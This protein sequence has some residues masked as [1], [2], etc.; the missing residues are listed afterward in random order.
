[1]GS[2]DTAIALLRELIAAQPDGEAAVQGVIARRLEAA[3]CAVA[4][5]DYDPA[6]V[7]VKGE[8]ALDTARATERR[9]AIVGTLPGDPTLPSLL[10]FAHPDAEPI[11]GTSAWHHDPFVGIVEGGRLH[12]WG[13]ADDLAGC[14]AAVLALEK[15]SVADVPLGRVV[16]AS[17]PSKR[18]ARGVAALL[19]DGLSA[20]A[21]LYLHPAESGLGMRE[22]K[23]VASGH[24][25]FRI[26]VTGRAPGTTE[27]GH[28][29]FAHLGVNPIDKALVLRSALMRLG[30][31]RASRI[32]HPLIEAV[33]GRATNINVSRI[34][35]GEMRRLSRMAETCTLGCAISFPPGETLDEVKTEI[36]ASIEAASAADAWLS[37]HPPVITF[38]A[39]VTGG[40][41]E[42]SHPLYRTAAAAVARVTGADPN[43]NPMH[44]SSDIRNPIVE[45]DIPCVGLGCLGGDLSQNDRH[46]EWIDVADFRRMV[47]VTADIV[48]NWCGG[49]VPPQS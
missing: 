8:F 10:I 5:H 1:M 46:D 3:G 43:V 44:T 49:V 7:T 31:R 42:A 33:V 24:L 36:T 37:E 38:V 29:A 45:A 26:T 6:A 22:I 13:V 25:E 35:A 39:G 16:F 30:E 19:H 40:E 28:T 17:T 23:A 4:A 34:E 14:A 48:T 9:R 15:A 21:A 47:D 11:D 18:Y 27:P 20:D 12:G 32:R 41:V 2:G